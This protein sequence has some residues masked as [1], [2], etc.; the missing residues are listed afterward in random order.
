MNTDR[1]VVHQV[2]KDLDVEQLV[3][4]TAH[5][6]KVTRVLQLVSP[7]HLCTL[8]IP[9]L[10]GDGTINGVLL[11]LCLPRGIFALILNKQWQSDVG[12]GIAFLPDDHGVIV[13]KPAKRDLMV[14]QD[15]IECESAIAFPLDRIESDQ[16]IVVEFKDRVPNQVKGFSNGR[17]WAYQGQN[18]KEN[19]VSYFFVFVFQWIM[20]HPT[21]H[22]DRSVDRCRNH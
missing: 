12:H 14:W 5:G 18:K 11:S 21:L 20:D 10:L 7:V 15:V 16:T 3:A 8:G 19:L 17:L 13:M 4:S 9:F 2:L 22:P 1:D 6:R